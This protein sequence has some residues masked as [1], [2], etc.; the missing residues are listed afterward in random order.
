MNVER[1]LDL[2]ALADVESPD[3]VRD[4]V[5]RF[6]RRVFGTGAVVAVAALALV[7]AALWSLVSHQ[8]LDERIERAPG[9]SLGIVFEGGGTTVV[10]ERVARLEDGLGLKL[11]LAAPKAR[12]GD[13]YSL[14]VDRMREF[15]VR[16]GARVQE[17]L[18]V[19]A[20]ATDGRVD[21]AV[22]LQTRCRNAGDVARC[23]GGPRFVSDFTIDLEE[24]GVA[25][26]LWKE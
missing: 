3:V 22:Q 26:E 14:R 16:G 7:A 19:V 24:L 9:E 8:T 20:P 12:S 25:E 21:V 5:R 17:H 11:L 15:D 4:A 10:V 6:R 23:G 1:P 2:R 13:A 18:L